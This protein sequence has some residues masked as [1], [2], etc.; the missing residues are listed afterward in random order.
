M[1][2]KQQKKN[3]QMINVMKLKKMHKKVNQFIYK[4]KKKISTGCIRDKN[5][6]ILFDEEKVAEIWVE[7]VQ[8][9]YNDQRDDMPQFMRSTGHKIL[10]AE[11][12]ST[13]KLMKYG[14]Q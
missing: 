11:V 4:Q 5:G 12:E 8:D 14:K 1:T 13:I 2:A 10:K 7:Y 9:F 3:G 6:N